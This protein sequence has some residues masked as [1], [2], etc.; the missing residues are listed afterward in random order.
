LAKNFDLIKD[1]LYALARTQPMIAAPIN[2]ELLIVERELN[3]TQE[4]LD[5]RRAGKAQSS[6]QM[7]MMSANNLSL[8]LGEVMDQMKS[9]M[10]SKS[11]CKK[12]GNCNKPGS[13]KPKPGFGKPKKQ[14]QSLKQQMQKMLDQMKDGKGKGKGNGKNGKKPTKGDLGKMIAEQEKM[15][16]MLQDLSNS[17]GISPQTAKKLREIKN[18]SEQVENDLINQ[19]ITPTTLKRQELILT[20]LLEAENSEF[21]RDQDNKRESN[22]VKNQKISNP[23]DIFKYKEEREINNDIL[24]KNNIKLKQ[25]YKEK[26]KKY[27]INLND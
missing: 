12:S 22:S 24:I 20:R 18:I 3:K 13:G 21:K 25:F 9:Q 23:K 17:Q 11:Q 2:K 5:D 6:Q 8:L 10:K 15:Q 7:V 4:A 16:K 26:Y 19:N 14:A 27:I 1:S